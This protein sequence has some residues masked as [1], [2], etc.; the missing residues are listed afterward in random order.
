MFAQGRSR[1]PMKQ[2]LGSGYNN[3]KDCEFSS[4]IVN[5]ISDFDKTYFDVIIPGPTYNPDTDEINA[6]TPATFEQ[7]FSQPLVMNPSE[8]YFTITRM[9]ICAN[10]I[11]VHIFEPIE[12]YPHETA[13]KYI[14]PSVTLKYGSNE[15]TKHLQ[16]IPH[17]TKLN[18][19]SNVYYY[20][21]YEYES[22]IT[23][24]N[25]A[26]Q[27]AFYELNNSNGGNYLPEGSKPPFM[28]FDS[29]L[30]TFSLWAQQSFYQTN[31]DG[32]RATAI[33][34]AD[35]DNPASNINIW[36]NPP[37]QISVNEPS[38]LFLDG[39]SHVDISTNSDPATTYAFQLTMLNSYN[40]L[41][42]YP[43]STSEIYIRNSQQYSTL[44]NINSVKSIQVQS[45]T[46]PVKKEYIPTFNKYGEITSNLT[47]VS[48]IK[49]FVPISTS[50]DPLR[51]YITYEAI[52]PYQLINMF[53]CIPIDKIDMKIVWTDKYGIPY[54]VP[55]F[56]NQSATVKCAFIKR[57]TF[58]S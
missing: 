22:F 48:I 50:D 20:A 51:T 10:T 3:L 52:G 24:F 12:I 2:T 32:S 45:T 56:Y 53:G 9:T 54:I 42:P 58:T 16:W 4:H 39:V 13:Q 21:I 5:D 1:I 43:T 28:T 11:P 47:S 30:K 31:G 8:Y 34:P 38:L 17:N 29:A 25:I 15:I 33:N 7:S 44:A 27:R 46:L 55:I 49:D 26:A 40:N 57:R 18:D 36:P 6:L 19:P 41:F 23:M 37:I 35:P 14:L